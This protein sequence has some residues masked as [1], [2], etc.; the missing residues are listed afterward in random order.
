[1]FKTLIL[2]N[3]IIRKVQ[4]HICN[5]IQY[6]KPKQGYP[7]LYERGKAFPTEQLYICCYITI[8]DKEAQTHIKT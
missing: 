7:A 3:I 8:T 6:Y 4:T 1:M 5:N 2:K